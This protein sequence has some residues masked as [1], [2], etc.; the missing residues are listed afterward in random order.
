MITRL[1]TRLS[2][3]AT[4]A[5]DE[6]RLF[7]DDGASLDSPEPGPVPPSVDETPTPAPELAPSEEIQP[8][9]SPA[10][11]IVFVDAN[12]R[13]GQPATVPTPAR[14]RVRGTMTRATSAL[15]GTATKAMSKARRRSTNTSDEDTPLS[16]K[17]ARLPS[18]K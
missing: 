2:S 12:S 14:N 7:T 17:R 5:L 11:P 1:R 10:S 3:I 6:F 13:S 9:P 8:D 15:K 18:K 4:G 16:L